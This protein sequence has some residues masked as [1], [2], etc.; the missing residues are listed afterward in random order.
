VQLFL[1]LRQGT[2]GG[3]V[4]LYQ[5]GNVVLDV[6]DLTTNDSTYGQWYL[7]NLGSG[8]TPPDSTLYVDDVTIS[9][10]L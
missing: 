5:D 7:G 10:S 9:A 8:L 3:E 6:T 2:N 1:K 4:A